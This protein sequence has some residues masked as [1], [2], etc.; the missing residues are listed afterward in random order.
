MLKLVIFIGNMR[1][2]ILMLMLMR[3][4]L[5]RKVGFEWVLLY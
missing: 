1:V 2:L 4:R 5:I 3:F